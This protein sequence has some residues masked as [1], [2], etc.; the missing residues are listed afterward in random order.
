M[1]IG[2]REHGSPE[3]RGPAVGLELARRSGSRSRKCAV[4]LLMNALTEHEDGS[5]AVGADA[6]RPFTTPPRAPGPTPFTA[7]TPNVWVI[8]GFKPDT[9]IADLSGGMSGAPPAIWGARTP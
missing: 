5:D 2:L 1:R 4:L 7:M 3:H 6:A 9:A 8:P